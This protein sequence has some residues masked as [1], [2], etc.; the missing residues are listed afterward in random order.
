MMLAARMA[1]GAFAMMM[2]MGCAAVPPAGEQPPQEEVIESRDDPRY[3][4]NAQPAQG[5]VGRAS[6]QELGTEA[7]RLSGA[8]TL[9]WIPEGS[10]VT[11]DYRSDRLNIEL[12]RQNKVT[13][14]RCG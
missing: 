12:D 4:C 14:I 11:M 1:T 9:R 3:T 13:R 8:R 6:S 7:M 10:A 5:L 2:S